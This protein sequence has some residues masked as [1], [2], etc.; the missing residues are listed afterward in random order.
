MIGEDSEGLASLEVVTED[1]DGVDDGEEFLFM[2]G[3][4]LFGGGKLARF[5]AD[6][7]GTISLVLEKNGTYTYSRSIG[8]EFKSSIGTSE[9]NDED[10]SSEKGSFELRKRINGGRRKRRRKGHSSLGQVGERS[11]DL[12]VILDEA[13]VE[14]GEA[15]EGA[16][17][18]Y[19][20]RQ[21]PVR[22]RGDLFWIRGNTRGGDEVTEE[23][24]GGLGEGALGDLGFEISSIESLE[25]R[26]KV[27]KM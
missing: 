20:M 5:V 27:I 22:D 11:G 17:R 25:N 24:S 8:V 15:E 9:G 18:G 13:T 23:P 10:R 7:L 19:V 2:D 26:T 1:L 12:G 6:G 4:I 21:R 3:V 14:S 16:S